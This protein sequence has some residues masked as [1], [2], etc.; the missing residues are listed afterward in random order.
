MASARRRIRSVRLRGRW[1]PLLGRSGP[2]PGPARPA[3]PTTQ[4]CA[5][6][7]KSTNAIRDGKHDKGSGSAGCKAQLNALVFN[8]DPNASTDTIGGT[9]PGLLR[10]FY[11]LPDNG[12]AGLSTV[13]L[14]L[15]ALVRNPL[16]D[17]YVLA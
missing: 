9:Q 14:I 6:A 1:A 13:G 7:G 11:N 8:P 10:Y 16:A 17:P 15:Q 5:S 3:P 4:A 12:G 2:W